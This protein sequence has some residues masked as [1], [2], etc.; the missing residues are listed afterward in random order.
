MRSKNYTITTLIL[1]LMLTTKSTFAQDIPFDCDYNAYLFQNNDVYALDLASGGSYQVAT[2]VTPGNINATGYNPADGYIWGSLS[3]PS[4][5]IVRIGKNFN[6]ATFTIPELP[7]N[8]R[9]IGDVSADG[10]YYLKP[11]GT[12]YYTID[13]DPESPNY[14]KYIATGTLSQN[15]SIHDWAFNA[16]DGQLYSVEKNSNHLYRINPETGVVTDLGEVPILSGYSYTYGAVYFD[17]SGRFYVSANQTG[18]IFVIQSVQD[19]NVNDQMDS[20]LFAYGPSSSSNDGARCPTAPVPQEICGNGIDDDGDGLIDCDD[21]SCSGVMD[22]PALGA[23]SGNEGGLESNNRLSQKINERN[24]QRSKNNYQFH[25]ENARVLE[26]TSKYGVAT[27]GSG[28]DLESFMP[29]DI[30]PETVAI[31]STPSDLLS[32]TNAT[33]ILS[34]DYNRNNETVAALMILKT[35]NGVYEHTKYICDRLLGAELL[36]VSTIDINGENFIKSIIKNPDGQVEFVLSLSAKLTNQDA[37]FSIESHWN[38]DRYENDAS[39]YNF[40]IWT[41]SIDELFTLSTEVLRLIAA[42]RPILDYNLSTPPPIFVKKGKYSNGVLDIELINSNN[43]TVFYLDGGV[44]KTETSDTE[45]ISIDKSLNNDFLSSH[46]IDTGFLFDIG[47]RISNGTSDTPDDLF[48]SDGPWGI[49]DFASSTNVLS[50]EITPTTDG[51]E[52]EGLLIERNVSMSATTSE[53]LSVYRSF[54]PK[55]QAVDLSGFNTVEFDALGTGSMDI[56]IIRKDISQWENQFRTT[57]ELSGTEKH[58]SLP[59]SQFISNNGGVID[60]SNATSILFTMVSE[61]GTNV[62]KELNLNNLIFTSREVT[63]ALNVDQE[64]V[65]IL[66][67]PMT[68]LSTIQFYSEKGTNLEFT[69]FDMTGKVVYRETISSAEGLN[70]VPVTNQNLKGGIYIYSLNG[71]NSSYQPGKL[72][73]K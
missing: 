64:L 73:V 9:Y 44:T 27:R 55:F 33:E 40:Q 26:R 39:F 34:V 10:V 43:S 53:Y 68:E 45:Y 5:T 8:N 24:F 37:N 22:C 56:T 14:T 57:I 17:L 32:I 7:S 69:I 60:F 61:D 20:N 47:F 49:D 6:V 29:I 46:K 66:P 50:F 59:Y 52:Q 65:Q 42:Q 72:I 48:M 63:Q 51:Q 28:F 3:S 23:S 54:T 67:N 19:L 25:K 13:L 1:V 18:T 62:Q 38:L 58:F 70:T 2:D 21:P 41:N 15:L 31:E 4:K 71:D 30:L 35:E 12:S 36:S 16:V 11:G